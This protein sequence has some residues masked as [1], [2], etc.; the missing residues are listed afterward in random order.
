MKKTNK[1][2]NNNRKIYNFLGDWSGSRWKN[3]FG[4]VLTYFSVCVKK[5]RKGREQFC[6]WNFSGWVAEAFCKQGQMHVGRTVLSK[7][8][9]G[10]QKLIART[11]KQD[12]TLACWFSSKTAS[13]AHVFAHRNTYTLLQS[14]SYLETNINYMLLCV[15]DA[16]LAFQWVIV[17]DCR[18]DNWMPLTLCCFASVSLS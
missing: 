17:L 1:Q 3:V 5:H 16:K 14:C 8:K 7:D 11:S 2:K 4:L 15:H 13:P 6:L 12:K 18:Q 10:V 9:T